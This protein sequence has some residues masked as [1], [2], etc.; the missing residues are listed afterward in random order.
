LAG[1]LLDEHPG[2]YLQTHVAEN[3]SEVAW[4]AELFPWSR[5][6]LDVYDRFGLVRPRSVYAH[7]IHLDDADRARMGAAGA[8]MAFCPT[9]NL[10]LRS[11][12]FAL[13]PAPPPAGRRAPPRGG[14][15]PRP[16]HRRRDIVLAAAFARRGLQGCAALRPATV[17]AVGVSS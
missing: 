4:A 10:F 13:S 15:R 14:G 8:A 17:T 6:Y 12:P 16:R 1:R 11:G 3:R 7:C 5:S 9:S 2:V